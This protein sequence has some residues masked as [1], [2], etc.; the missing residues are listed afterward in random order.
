MINKIL[1]PLD[2]S[3][4]AAKALPYAEEFAHKFQAEL[5]LVWVLHP[6]MHFSDEAVEVYEQIRKV[7]KE[8]AK[9]YLKTAPLALNRLHLQPQT[10]VLEGPVAQ[11]ILDAAV[12]EGA[13]LIIM[14]THGRSGLGRWVFGSVASKVLQ[15]APCPVFLVKAGNGSDAEEV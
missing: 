1:V 8:E 11:T 6:L 7:E 14:S 12:E 5:L 3:A 2:G 15:R 10:K 9:T 4:L 13:D